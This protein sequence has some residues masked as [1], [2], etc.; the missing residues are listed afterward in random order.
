M[1]T[2]DPDSDGEDATKRKRASTSKSEPPCNSKGS[3]IENDKNVSNITAFLIE[4]LQPV[5]YTQDAAFRRYSYALND[6][7]RFPSVDCIESGLTFEY[8]IARSRIEEELKGVQFVSLSTECWESYLSH[9]YVTIRA[10]FIDDE[11]LPHSR[12]LSTRH[13]LSHSNSIE[14]INTRIDE[15]STAWGIRHKITSVTYDKTE[16]GDSCYGDRIIC[17]AQILQNSVLSA[18]AMVNDVKRMIGKC[19]VLVNHFHDDRTANMYLFKYQKSIEVPNVTLPLLNPNEF[20][21]LYPFLKTILEQKVTINAV[22]LD[23]GATKRATAKAIALT[24]MEWDLIKQVLSI[25]EPFELAK[26]I[27][28]QEDN[29][30]GIVSVTKP[31][32]DTLCKNFLLPN[33]DKD[34]ELVLALK[35]CI[36]QE[37][38]VNYRMYYNIGDHDI[39]VP[40]CYD[41]AMYLDPRYKLLTCLN[42]RHRRNVC[43]YVNDRISRTQS[44]DAQTSDEGQGANNGTSND[45]IITPSKKRRSAVE[46]LFT[47]TA[48]S[49]QTRQ[50]AVECCK[51][52]LEPE[53]DR[54][55]SF[56]DWWKL[57]EKKYPSLAIEARKYLC[58]RATSKPLYSYG[59][60]YE[61]RTMLPPQH[62]DQFIFLYNNGDRSKM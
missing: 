61:R 4:T 10:H 31:L 3:S 32:I 38:Q 57:R 19:K 22:L 18:V 35:K 36:R 28:F 62:V 34:D 9:A 25:L 29:I 15:V 24:A 40:D 1:I 26:S 50:T 56:Y 2:L 17:V 44:G 30:E 16:F 27:I 52:N 47:M 6:K 33:A 21:A 55:L 54:D 46:I 5:T 48:S 59:K 42:D 8:E 37:L 12:V 39:G 43:Q 7:Y 45:E 60:F 51:Y 20:N 14:E 13:L 11:W 49:E 53:I 41:I 23:D 58:G